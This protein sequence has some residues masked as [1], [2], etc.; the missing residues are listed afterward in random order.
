[1]KEMELTMATI[2]GCS[3]KSQVLASM[4]MFTDPRN[5]PKHH[6]WQSKPPHADSTC[7]QTFAFQNTVWLCNCLPWIQNTTAWFSN[8]R[9][10]QV[11]QYVNKHTNS[12]EGEKEKKQMG[13]ILSQLSTGPQKHKGLWTVCFNDAWCHGQKFVWHGPLAGLHALLKI[14]Y[15]SANVALQPYIEHLCPPMPIWQRLITSTV[16][17]MLSFSCKAFKC[18][19]LVG[20]H[21]VD[22]GLDTCL[23]TCFVT[24]QVTAEAP[25]HLL[26]WKG[27][28]KKERSVCVRGESRL[29]DFCE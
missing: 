9:H 24:K 27:T 28:R 10:R 18:I 15:P 20:S 29:K 1:M 4:W 6:F 25:L 14:L 2:Q 8:C 21:S 23:G 7:K 11:A 5:S 22:I 26:L 19:R 16:I 13:H 12:H 17:K 3:G